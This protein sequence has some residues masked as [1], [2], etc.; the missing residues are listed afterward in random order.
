VLGTEARQVA[1]RPLRAF[2]GMALIARAR[3]STAGLQN[4]LT[5]QLHSIDKD[6]PLHDVHPLTDVVR[7]N[8]AQ[9]RFTMVLLIAFAGLALALSAI[10]LYGVLAFTVAQRTQ[11][12]GIRMA[13]GA[14][15]GDVLRMILGQGVL[16]I[17]IGIA[18]GT[19]GSL[20]LMRAMASLLFGVHASDPQTF[21]LV[22]AA[23]AG[24][25]LLASYIPAR[26]AAKV[27][28]MVALRYE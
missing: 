23:L 19:A 6:L 3:G 28:P 27:D 15:A 20:L 8:V 14:Q 24:V 5:Q 18:I 22:A 26:R 9:Q 13:L 1:Y 2:Q 7:D 11:E 12:I 17:A 21:V 16:A 10:G 25:A 4:A